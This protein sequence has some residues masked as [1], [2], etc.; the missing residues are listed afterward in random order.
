MKK[1]MLVVMSHQLTK[2]QVDDFG[3]EV[4]TLNELDATLAKQ[5]ANIPPT[6]DS[7]YIRVL[8]QK[9]MMPVLFKKFTHVAIMGEPTLVY[10]VV[11]LCA[12][13]NII[14]LTSTT[15]RI[16]V[17]EVQPDGSVVKKSIFKHVQWREML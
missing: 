15:E 6:Q 3:G 10:H 11:N 17:D 14:P 8:A 13:M 12:E 1:K 4:I 16:S 5:C 9:V 2:E 7:G